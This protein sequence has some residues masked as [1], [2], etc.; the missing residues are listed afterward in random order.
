MRRQQPFFIDV[1]G[2]E[3]ILGRG[4]HKGRPHGVRFPLACFFTQ[5]ATTRVAPTFVVDTL[6]SPMSLHFLR[7]LSSI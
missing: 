4:D 5:W 1:F 3:V 2:T 7:Y 6:R